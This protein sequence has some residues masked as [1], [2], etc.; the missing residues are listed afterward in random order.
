MA[1]EESLPSSAR[2]LLRHPA[3]KQEV[4]EV[5]RPG[6]GRDRDGD[7]GR[8]IRSRLISTRESLVSRLRC[9]AAGKR[10]GVALARG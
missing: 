4:C 9:P 8:T 2:L 5:A 10:F 7:M 1:P 6:V 3:V